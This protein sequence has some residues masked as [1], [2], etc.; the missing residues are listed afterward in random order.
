MGICLEESHGIRAW[1]EGGLN[2]TLLAKLRHKKE[3]HRRWKQGQVGQE[4]HGGTVQAC[5]DMVRKAKAY[6]ETNS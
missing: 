4:K 6:L 5:R 1:R 2:K 3:V